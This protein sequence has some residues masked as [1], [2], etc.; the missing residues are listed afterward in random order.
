MTKPTHLTLAAARITVRDSDESYVVGR[1]VLTMEPVIIEGSALG[2]YRTPDRYSHWSLGLELFRADLHLY[3]VLTR[4]GAGV[5]L[6]SWVAAED[7]GP[8]DY[9]WLYCVIARVTFE[10]I[11]QWTRTLWHAQLSMR[12]KHDLSGR[13]WDLSE[14]EQ[15][16]AKPADVRIPWDFDPVRNWAFTKCESGPPEAAVAADLSAA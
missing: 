2:P 12:A 13:S 4:P 11:D 1:R 16:F 10:P 15:A 7:F 8:S 3:E 14:H 9:P 5:S 6:E